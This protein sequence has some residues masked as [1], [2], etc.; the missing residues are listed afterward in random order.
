MNIQYKTK[1]FL[2]PPGS[3]LLHATFTTLSSIR[4]QWK[5]GDD[6]DAAVLGFILSWRQDLTS[7][8]QEWKEQRLSPRE[9][10]YQLSGLQCGTPY[11]L[12]MSAW[13]V[14]GSGKPSAIIKSRTKGLKPQTLAQHELI[15]VNNTVITLQL[16]KWKDGGCPIR[17]FAIY[18]KSDN[19]VWHT[20]ELVTYN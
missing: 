9:Q 18:Y 2:V 15:V 5:P 20:C 13:N 14:I 8:T 19:N 17:S 4:L 1:D 7:E 16:R 6:G 12:Y 10:S 3:P 11:E